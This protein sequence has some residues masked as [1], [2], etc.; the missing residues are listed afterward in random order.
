M[1]M[2]PLYNVVA[3]C[4]TYKD[5]DGNKVQKWCKCGVSVDTREGGIA[6]KI[7]TLPVEWDGWLQLAIPN[8]KYYDY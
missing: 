5:R 6:L 8:D 2:T 4:G 3:K 1:M 7:E